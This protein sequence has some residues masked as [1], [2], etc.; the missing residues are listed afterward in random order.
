M[1]ALLAGALVSFLNFGIHAAMTAVIVVTTRR[2]A[3][4]TGHLGIFLRL[5]ALLTVT[6][7][8]LMCAHVAEVAVWAAYLD[9]GG[10]MIKGTDAFEYA[11]ENYTG[12]G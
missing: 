7:A 8:A 3:D 2:I 12:L 5:F 9:F 10:V 4:R 6:M 1:R 11:F